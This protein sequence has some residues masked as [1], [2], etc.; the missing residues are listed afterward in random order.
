MCGK[1]RYSMIEP[2]G[3]EPYAASETRVTQAADAD[4]EGRQFM[5]ILSTLTLGTRRPLRVAAYCRVSTEEEAQN[6]SYESQRAF[7]DKEIREH[8]D[9]NMTAIYGDRAK[10]GTSVERRLG[11]KRMIKH[12][13][14]G[15]IDYIITKSI[16][17]FSRSTTD[18]ILTL[19][20]LKALGVGVYF[21]EQGIDTLSDVGQIIINTLATISEMES[22]SISQNIKQTMDSMNEK[23]AP[24]RRSSYG[25]KRDGLDW[26][27]V[28]REALRIKLAFLM[29]AE[30]Y[31]FAETAARLNQ[32]ESRDRTGRE[33]DGSMVKYA[34]TNETYVGDVLTNKHI[35][36]W[37]G[38]EKKILVND[39]LTDQF[40]I[41]NHH[42]PMVGRQLYD[43][44]RE[45]VEAGTLAGQKNYQ[46]G[47]TEELQEL[48]ILAKRDHFL[49]SVRK[50]PPYTKGRY[51]RGI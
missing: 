6:E 50:Y 18:I 7:F 51:V 5:G 47:F 42:E 11:F 13:E 38:T 26:T 19:R 49:D 29:T 22:V 23:G 48:K 44:M 12:A 45:M 43:R 17:R 34:L 20:K 36:I 37:D 8:P 2:K 10:S 3:N 21:M 25:Y 39:G 4:R 16:T 27:I 1:V 46:G 31:S 40:Y 30:G 24:V 28:P 33:W 9:W 15:C 35:K 14:A 41:R 32:F